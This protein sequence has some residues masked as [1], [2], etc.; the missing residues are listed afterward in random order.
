MFLLRD[1]ARKYINMAFDFITSRNSNIN[2]ELIKF[3]EDL[4]KEF[5]NNYVMPEI[6]KIA[7]GYKYPLIDKFEFDSNKKLSEILIF[8]EYEIEDFLKYLKTLYLREK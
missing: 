3:I 7:T 5:I 2:A 8:G 1:E 6:Y 4:S